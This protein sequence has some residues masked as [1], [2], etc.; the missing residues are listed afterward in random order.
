MHIDKWT[1]L[2]S[3]N[4]PQRYSTPIVLLWSLNALRSGWPPN[5]PDQLKYSQVL[6]ETLSSAWS[7]Q[8]RQPSSTKSSFYKFI[9][10]KN[11]SISNISVLQAMRINL[12]LGSSDSKGHAALLRIFVVFLD[13]LIGQAASVLLPHCPPSHRRLSLSIFTLAGNQCGNK[14]FTCFRFKAEI[15]S[16]LWRFLIVA[17]LLSRLLTSSPPSVMFFNS[18]STASLEWISGSLFVLGFFF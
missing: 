4:Q 11:S 5:W 6:L 1:P 17:V 16:D 3:S 14:L 7:P 15:V 18:C 10:E 8:K 13:R 2:S 9:P 12:W